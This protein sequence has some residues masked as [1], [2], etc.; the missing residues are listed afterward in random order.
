MSIQN[1]SISQ[2]S[3]SQLSTSRL[4]SLDF[5]KALS[6]VAAVSYHSLFIPQS[7]YQPF[8]LT[9]EVLFSPL[10]FCVPVFFTISFLLLARDLEQTAHSWQFLLKK[11]ILRISIPIVFWFGLT[12]ILH[13]LRHESI[14]SL[15]IRILNGN[16]FKG[17]YFLVALLQL[18][19][20]FIVFKDSFNKFSFL[21]YTICLQVFFVTSVQ[22]L[23]GL[24]NAGQIINL[25]RKI[26]RPFLLYWISYVS[27]G[28][29][30]WK[31]WFALVEFSSK[32]SISLKVSLLSLSSM[33]FFAEQYHLF[34]ISI[35]KIQPFEYATISCIISVL[36]IFICSADIRE[37]NLPRVVKNI[38]LV[39]SKYSLGIFCIN[40]IL[41]EV[42][43][44]VGTHFLSGVS[45]GFLEIL[46]M[47]TIGWVFLL[48]VS[49][50]LSLFLD[51]C[52]LSVVV[53]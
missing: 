1:A 19:V 31:N 51:R 17:A 50:G 25:L 28:I 48:L 53:R 5:L 6:I 30:F 16:I 41:S 34:S 52:G 43:L 44:S 11:R 36:I 18:T 4:F 37:I 8:L 3:T 38:I 20:I 7:A 29:F 47:K 9:L 14:S 24:D 39:L 45:F 15:A 12:T 42:F 2:L 46:I 26:D 21:L 10:R 27:L 13:L 49:L 33:L 22:I 23:L 35:G 40:G 32:V